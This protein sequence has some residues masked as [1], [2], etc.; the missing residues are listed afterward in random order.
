MFENSPHV[1]FPKGR[2]FFATVRTSSTALQVAAVVG[3]AAAS[4]GFTSGIGASIEIVCR[5]WIQMVAC[6]MDQHAPDQNP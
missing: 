1:T 6:G 3:A 5:S 4:S 2:T